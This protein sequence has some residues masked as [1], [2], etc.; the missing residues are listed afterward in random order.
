M[1]ITWSIDRKTPEWPV[2]RGPADQQV[3]LGTN[4]KTNVTNPSEYNTRHIG[5]NYEEQIE[6]HFADTG[7]LLTTFDYFSLMIP[8][9]QMWQGYGGIIYE[10]LND[11][12]IIALKV[13]P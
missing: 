2:L 1:T 12:H 6:W 3:L 11:V 4:I 8:L 13:L 9:F 5:A 10:G 7:K